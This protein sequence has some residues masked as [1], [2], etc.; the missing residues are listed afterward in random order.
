MQLAGFAHHAMEIAAIFCLI[1]GLAAGQSPGP[2]AGQKSNPDDPT[3]KEAFSLFEQHK[4]LEAVP[5]LEKVVN[6]YPEDAIAHERL[7]VA[8]VSR[9]SGWSEPER[10]KVDRYRARRELI[11]ARDL[12]SKSPLSNV[13]LEDIPED[14][15]D[16]PF[17]SKAEVDAAM[18]RGEAAFANG[19]WNTALKEYT[20]A[21]D[22]DPK[23]YLA[24]LDLG[25]TYFRMK[26][27]DKAGEWF[28]RA[29]QIEPN[30]ETAYRYWGD[31]LMAASRMKEAR[32]KFI[33]ALV[34]WPY[35][36]VV[37]D[38]LNHWVQT[39]NLQYKNVKMQLPKGP[40]VDEKGNVNISIDPATL[41][42]PGSAAWMSYSM[43][44]ALWPKEKFQK[45]FPQETTYRH[46]LKE[47]VAALSSVATV[48]HELAEADA[49]AGK[50]AQTDPQLDLLSKL[51][52]DGM[53]EA[54]VLILHPDQG[55][56]G[57]FAAYQAAHRDKLLEFLDKY[58]VPEVP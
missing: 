4:M 43:E 33:G 14:G 39:N 18:K 34:A 10:R 51:K 49:K 37:W 2:G 24:A 58:M 45:E 16:S 53:L 23:L 38:G 26:Q 3:R 13:L 28:A 48:Y 22:L 32:M 17:S 9:A 47:E 36:Q 11:I 7:G 8:L 12:G 57:D 55:I 1:G 44:R 54:F 15:S 46:T 52:K 21:F 19:D 6:K 56:A 40:T 35:K 31:A 30:Q 27:T 50:P 25:D 42:K 5:L 41:G 29:I 20:L